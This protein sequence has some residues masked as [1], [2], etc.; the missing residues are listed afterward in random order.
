MKK[1]NRSEIM[2]NAWVIYR[3]NNCRIKFGSALKTAWNKAK[4]AV[5]DRINANEI[6]SGDTLYIE[7][8]DDDNWITCTVTSTLKKNY[9]RKDFMVVYFVMNDG[10]KM[11][12]CS[13]LTDKVIRFTKGNVE[14]A[15]VAKAA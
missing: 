2:T 13:D 11:E 5:A 6:N 12:F 15:T 4:A 9:G 3:N 7:Y 1:Y 14:A 10:R 8:G